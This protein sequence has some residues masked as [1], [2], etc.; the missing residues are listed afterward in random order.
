MIVL[1]ADTH[2]RDFVDA[3]SAPLQAVRPPAA[4][5]RGDGD[6]PRLA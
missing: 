2:A 3:R 1:G 4:C 6:A 5:A